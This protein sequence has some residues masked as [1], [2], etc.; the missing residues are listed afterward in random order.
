MSLNIKNE[1][2]VRLVRELAARTGESQTSAVEHAV[3]ARLAALGASTDGGEREKR[4]ARARAVL[5]DLRA[6][7]TDADRAAVREAQQ[8]LY[9]EAGLPR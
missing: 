2:T 6:T 1:R 5:D 3:A 9:D 4:N 7:L 8:D